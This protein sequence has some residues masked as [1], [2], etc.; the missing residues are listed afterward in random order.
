MNFS[1]FRKLYSPNRVDEFA[2]PTKGGQ[3]RLQKVTKKNTF[4]AFRESSLYKTAGPMITF[5][6]FAGV[7]CYYFQSERV[8]LSLIAIWNV[9]E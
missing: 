6:A 5:V 8:C 1:W 7:L 4:R 2:I 3:I 9:R